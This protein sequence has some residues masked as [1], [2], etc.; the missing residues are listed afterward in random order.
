MTLGGCPSS[1]FCSRGT[2]PN[3][4]SIASP[5]TG[6]QLE[7]HR[8]L[9]QGLGLMALRSLSF[10][11]SIP[12]YCCLNTIP[13]SPLRVGV[14][15]LPTEGAGCKTRSVVALLAGWRGYPR[16]ENCYP[17]PITRKACSFEK[18]DLPDLLRSLFRILLFSLITLKPR[19]K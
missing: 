10:L 15:L 17:K 4:E 18:P 7:L 5:E 14:A 13:S 16:P 1:I 2:P 9:L 19:V 12:N 3:P 6:V 8:R 11:S